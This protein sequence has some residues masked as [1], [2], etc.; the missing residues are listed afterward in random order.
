MFAY[1]YVWFTYLHI[2]LRILLFWNRWMAFHKFQLWQSKNTDL[3]SHCSSLLNLLTSNWILKRQYKFN[4]V[5]IIFIIHIFISSTI[6]LLIYLFLLL[7]HGLSSLF[8]S[9]E[10]SYVSPWFAQYFGF[11][12]V[13]DGLQGP[14][15]TPGKRW[16]WEHPSGIWKTTCIRIISLPLHG[17]FDVKHRRAYSWYNLPMRIAQL[18]A[19]PQLHDCDK[20]S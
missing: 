16:Q 14:S 5:Y 8:S 1:S 9:V 19:D 13:F 10:Q 3:L 18:L 2:Y 20:G 4:H 6:S 12:N 11:V 17:K 7:I 15:V